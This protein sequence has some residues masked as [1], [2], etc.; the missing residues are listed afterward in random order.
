[1]TVSSEHNIHNPPARWSA[2]I[3]SIQSLNCASRDLF[4]M[5][6]AEDPVLLGHCLGSIGNRFRSFRRSMEPSVSRVETSRFS[7]GDVMSNNNGILKLWTVISWFI[8]NVHFL[9]EGLSSDKMSTSRVSATCFSYL[10]MQF[11]HTL[12]FIASL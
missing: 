8:L 1:M 9:S 3:L 12:I 7:R 11:P 4:A 2:G 10:C 5:V 6:L